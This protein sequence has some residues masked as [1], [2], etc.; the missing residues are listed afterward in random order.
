MQ[1]K[2]RSLYR[3]AALA[4]VAVFMFAMPGLTQ[5]APQALH[6]H[7]PPV[8]SSGRAAIVGSLPSTQ[9]LSLSIVLP[10]RNEAELDSLLG[11]IYDPTSPN[12][13]HFLSVQQFTSR[14]GPTAA[15][16]QTVVNFARANGLTVTA[17]L[18]NRLVV[19]VRGT[20]AQIEGA[21]QIKLNLYQHPTENRLFYST[22]REPSLS[23]SVPIKHITGLDNISIPRPALTPGT[24]AATTGSGSYG[25][26]LPSDMRAAYYGTGPLTG[27]GQCVALVEFGG[28]SINDVAN[29]FDGAATDSAN[30]G[31]Y[32]LSYTTQG[33]NYN[34]P[35]NNVLVD[36][37]S[38]GTYNGDEVEVALD[39]AQPIGMAPGMSQVRVYIA[40]DAWMNPGYSPDQPIN[41]ND[42]LIYDTIASDNVCKQI[43]Q[44]WL[45]E[46]GTADLYYNDGV[47][48]AM[49]SNGQ[50]FFTASGDHGAFDSS[51]YPYFY[52]A[53]DANVTAVGGTDLTTSGPVGVWLSEA[54][55]IDSGGG[56]SPDGISVP[57]YQ[58]GVANSLNG[59][60]TTLRNVPDVAMEANTDNYFC[61]M[62]QC[63]PNPTYPTYAEGGTSYAAPRWA[64]FMALVNQQAVANGNPPVGFINPYI[65]TIGGGPNYYSDFHD[66]LQ[67]SGNNNCCGQPVWFNAEDGYDL[68]TGWGSPNGQNLIIDLAQNL[69]LPPPPPPSSGIITTIAGNGTAGYSGDGGSATAAELNY[70]SGIALDASGNFYVADA[71]NNAIRKVTVSTGE[72]SSAFA[73]LS[74]AWFNLPLGV[75]VDTSG[76]VYVADTNNN[77]IV[78]AVVSTENF[79]AIAGQEDPFLFGYTGDGGYATSA[80]LNYPYAVTVDAAENIYIA[81]TYNNVIRK[82]TASTGIITTIAGD[83]SSCIY[84]P[85][86]CVYVPSGQYSGDGGLATSAGLNAPD[87]VAVDT[88]GNIYIADW[89]NNR[90]RKVTAST[91][92]ITTIAGNGAAGYS[93]DGGQATSAQL[94]YPQ[95]VAVDADGNVYIADMGNS[96]IRKIAAS[97]GIITT[98]AGNGTA[99]YF[100]DGGSATSA[101][102]SGPTGVAVDATGNV[103]I[104]D[105]GNNRIRKV[106]Y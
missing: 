74:F 98:I 9:Q 68:V 55:W 40:P 49:A 101:A 72:I 21:F 78:E 7:V 46:P 105:A 71:N 24:L 4:C 66:I 70:P 97:T 54:T 79:R 87:G 32:M 104:A 64:G 96:R 86:S 33:V 103:Y 60:S 56:I 51:V 82:I 44:S 42:T 99:G 5:Q 22:D 31:N 23:L 39:I 89:F 37:G 65:Y 2:I 100:G 41:S 63:Y 12:Y 16:Y 58:T 52:P 35:V 25:S 93:G 34:I 57:T 38:V 95:G 8:V 17:T 85:S 15:D 67:G 47:F 13:R 77:G 36:G 28:Y 83:G 43:S 90:I 53:E 84:D 19:P 92:I 3:S 45:W 1:S 75:T 50:S 69:N 6:N 88:A 20:V 27:S 29:T 30:G 81:D 61:T 91:G 10:L 80:E 11:Q 59:G 26:F 62:N 94:Y 48:K 106:T 73:G 102:L 76:N 18:A 14:F